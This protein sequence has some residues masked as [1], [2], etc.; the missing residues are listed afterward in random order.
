MLWEPAEGGAVRCGL[1]RR[2]CLIPEGKRGFCRVRE[3]RGGRLYSLNYGKAIATNVDPIEKKP[4][5]HFMPGDSVFSFSTV[6][7]N[8]ACDY[9]FPPDTVVL[10]DFAPKLIEDVFEESE[11]TPKEE[12]RLPKDKMTVCATGEGK[13]I[14]KS[15]RHR[16]EGELVKIKPLYLPPVECTPNHMFFVWDGK[17]LCKK[18][19]S[20][21][22][23]RDY[24]VVPKIKVGN[25]KTTRIE[26]RGILKRR[27]TSVK[28]VRKTD[29]KK[30]SEILSMW[31]KGLTSLEIGKKVGMHPVYLR[32]LI[33][34][35]KREGINKETFS[36]Q[37]KLIR[38]GKLIRFK[39]EKGWIP[40]EL[41]VDEE[42]AELLGYY[43]AEGSTIAKPHRLNSFTITFSFGKGEIYLA[44]RTAYLLRKIFKVKPVVAKRRT[45]TTVTVGSSSLGVFLKE[46]CGERATKKKIP[47]FLF[48]APRKVVEAYLRAYI[49]GD[50][51]DTKGQIA[52]NTVS[53]E[54][55][56][57]T[58]YLL[59]RLEYLPAFYEWKPPR[60]KRIEGR[61]VKQSTLYYVKVNKNVFGKKLVGGKEDG[62]GRKVRF[63]DMG[64]FWAVPVH[65]ISRRAYSG[66]VYNMEV[67]GEH[68]Y[69]ANFVA[70]KNCQNWDIS[71]GFREIGGEN[72]PPE[73][74][75]GIC[76]AQGLPGAACTY[77]EPTVFMEYALDTAKLL[78]KDGRY[79]VFV[80]NGYMADE[81][82][83]EMKGRIDATRVDLKG[84]HDRIYKE[85]CK[86]VELEGVLECIKGL[87]KIGHI[88]IINLIVPGY[89][90]DEDDIRAVC[91]WVKDL[92]ERVPVHFI[93]FYPAHRM[94]DVKATKL[95]ALLRA[96]EIAIEEGLLHAYTGNVR[97]EET[98][99]TY[100]PKCGE[101]VVKRSG[102]SML[103]NRVTKEGR[104]PCGEQLYF[105]NDIKEYWKKR[106][107]KG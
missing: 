63:K 10:N 100:C 28:K 107:R 93:A 64:G 62:D 44:E 55:A 25:G 12:V 85:V 6:G 87:H 106:P 27:Q 97:N 21:L 15:F 66:Y 45:T 104:C 13:K 84:F 91:K 38:K 56:V 34:K 88:E 67:E 41:T 94:M 82:I 50:G 105:V 101:M 92:D 40:A 71:Q 57:G 59:L 24:I 33:N 102:F 36:Y 18:A 73:K 61:I 5:Y 81:A 29:G 72:L 11:E 31:K 16:Y 22:K 60:T 35:L 58:Y 48:R 43:V 75:A 80:S 46:I 47:Y 98:E 20:E 96:R 90:D 39:T 69:L 23:D 49:V 86:D 37:N 7:C 1:C 8:F 17:G 2:R 30:L 95:E 83:T 4:F 99:S 54:L 78:H 32:K 65:K 74:I 14:S 79:N 3:N 51:T 42:L 52:M 76:K 70:V 103:E 77:T 9:C 53:K 68:S 89:N 19:A 26:V